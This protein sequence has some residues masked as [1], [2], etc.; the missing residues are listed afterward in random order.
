MKARQNTIRGDHASLPAQADWPASM[1]DESTAAAPYRRPI[2]QALLLFTAVFG[3][4]FAL[5]NYHAGDYALMALELLMAGFAASLIRT[6]ARTRRLQLWIM[7]FLLP[8]FTV[9]MF[10]L[11]TAAVVPSVF[12]WVLLI[13]ILSYLLLG[14]WLGAA[15]AGFYLA[16]SGVIFFAQFGFEHGYSELRSLANV[17]LVAIC[18]FGFSHLY[19]AS[20]EHAESRLRRMAQTDPL[21]GLSNR[22]HLREVFMAALARDDAAQAMPLTLL[23]L[24]LDHFKHINDCYGHEAGDAVLCMAARVMRE[25]LR[26]QDLACRIGGEEFCVLLRDT[27]RD[28]AITLAEDLC[29][30]V[31]AQPCVYAGQQISLSTSIGIAEFGRDGSDLDSLLRVADRRLYQAK[32]GGR[33]RVVA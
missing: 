32:T 23:M 20:R 12:A 24:D 17:V 13:P 7:V 5:L 8:F 10:A 28:A 4:L 21:T 15:V 27:H 29:R 6:I 25:R 16:V 11:T 30:R 14:R 26:A 1:R 31:R 19:E 9:M 3:V 22:M 33:D 18:I 2:T